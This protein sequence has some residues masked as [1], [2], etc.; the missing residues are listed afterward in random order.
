MVVSSSHQVW[1]GRNNIICIGILTRYVR[2]PPAT[3]GLGWTLNH[4]APYVVRIG[5]SERAYIL[6][7]E[8]VFHKVEGKAES[9]FHR[10]SFK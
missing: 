10:P 2:T 1:Q 4:F 5:I 7:T 6:G 3:A 8:G 9:T